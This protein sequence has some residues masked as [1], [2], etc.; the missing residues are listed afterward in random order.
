MASWNALCPT[1]SRPWTAWVG[2]SFLFYWH[3]EEFADRY[4][5]GDMPELEN[6]LRNAFEMLGDLILFLK[7][8]DVSPLA[9]MQNM[10]PTVEETGV[11]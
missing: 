4:G 8:K 11:V 5:K 9:G 2:S 10:S 6:T 7:E 3:N 1:C